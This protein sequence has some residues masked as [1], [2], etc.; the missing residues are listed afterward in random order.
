MPTFTLWKLCLIS[1]VVLFGIFAANSIQDGVETAGRSSIAST[2]DPVRSLPSRHLRAP[3]LAKRHA[4]GALVDHGAYS[5][6]FAG[7][8]F[9]GYW[10]EVL[11]Y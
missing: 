4:P 8:G 3:S 10:D 6:P 2:S 9:D 7:A 5:V 11:D 1:I